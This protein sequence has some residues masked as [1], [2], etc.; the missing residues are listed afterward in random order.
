MRNYV[1]NRHTKFFIIIMVLTISS[2]GLSAQS[3]NGFDLSNSLLNIEDIYR[4]GPPRDGIPSISEPDFIS[5][6]KVDY[7]K[8]DDIVIGLVRKET[9]R[10]YPTRI[11]IWHE[12]VNDTI[13]GEPVIVTYCPLCGTS[14]VFDRKIKGEVRDFGVSGL[15]Y[16]SD[17]LMYD[18]ETD[19][20]WSQLEMKSISGPEAGTE[21]KWLPSEYMTWKAWKEKYPGGEV[22]SMD[23]G[24]LRNYSANAYESYFSTDSLMFPVPKYR[25]ELKNKTLVIGILLNGEPKAYAIDS[26][27]SSK[28][29]RDSVGG[30]EIIISYNHDQK[31]PIVKN[32][33]REDIPFV[34]SFWFAWQAFY[35]QTDL[36]HKNQ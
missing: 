26:F 17:V 13:E 25:D 35:P 23:T 29:I 20:L 21:L 18:R 8:D 2:Y 28:E 30:E 22:L 3:L 1:L 9:A 10:A 24:Y 4:G 15:L 36:W 33:R 27:E 34:I 7:L 32:S 16:Q 11:L 31:Y 19:S 14:M 6:D 12:I 5:A